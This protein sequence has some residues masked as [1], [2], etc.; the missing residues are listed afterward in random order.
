MATWPCLAWSFPGH[1]AA[2]LA[3]RVHGVLWVCIVVTVQQ[4]LEIAHS[5]YILLEQ[6]TPTSCYP[7]LSPER[8][9]KQNLLFSWRLAAEHPGQSVGRL[10]TLKKYVG[11]RSTEVMQLTKISHWSL[12]LELSETSSLWWLMCP[13]PGYKKTSEQLLSLFK[14]QPKRMCRAK[15]FAELVFWKF[16]NSFP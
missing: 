12:P 10:T 2:H 16:F 11:M 8:S 5:G 6:P 7:N 4:T 9:R 1:S 13:K 14:R 15:T 3:W